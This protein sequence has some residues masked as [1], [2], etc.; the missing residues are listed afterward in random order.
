MSISNAHGPSRSLR[1][2]DVGRLCG[3]SSLRRRGGRRRPGRAVPRPRPLA[4]PRRPP[5]P[6][7]PTRCPTASCWRWP[8]SSPWTGKPVPGPARL[9]FLVPPRR[10]AGRRPSLEDEESNVF[11][12]AMVYDGATGPRLLTLAGTAAAVKTWE[13]TDSGLVAD[14]AVGGGLRRQVEPHARRRGRRPLRRR[15]QRASPSR[16]T[17]RASWRC[18]APAGD[19]FEVDRARRASPTPSSTRSRSATSTATAC[20][21][22]T[23]PPA[24]RTAWTA[25][26]QSGEVVRYVPATGEGRVVVADLGD[27]HAKEIL[28]DDV[29]G[30]GRD[31]LYVSVEGHIE[32]EG[33]QKR[34]VDP[35]E[36]RASTP[37]P[38]PPRAS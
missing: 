30:D 18:S 21:R 12:K 20:S 6:R 37:T 15:R 17:T 27:R 31:E 36:I 4:P 35:V 9:E 2:A 34:L 7:P 1:C 22:S 32:G 10:R 38:R 33:A 13:K 16:P 11:H 3:V 26:A 5:P 28:V 8:S 23:P 29:D 24:S 25:R 14:D 19:G